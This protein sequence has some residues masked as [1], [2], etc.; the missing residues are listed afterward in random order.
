LEFLF[1]LNDGY[2][3]YSGLEAV[4]VILS[5]GRRKWVPAHVVRLDIPTASAQSELEDILSSHR[6]YGSDHNQGNEKL[7]AL[8]W[9]KN[10]GARQLVAEGDYAAG[11]YDVASED[12]SVV[13]ECGTTR[14]DKFLTTAMSNDWREFVLV[15]RF[16]KLAIVF[17]LTRRPFDRIRSI[18]EDAHDRARYLER[19][20]Q[21]SRITKD[22]LA[23]CVTET[24]DAFLEKYRK[25]AESLRG[26][27]SP[28]FSFS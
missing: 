15:P 24:N 14:M 3:Q 18:G 20:C 13:V 7:M 22:S 4:D 2:P 8:H 25:I 5:L 16:L 19:V 11:R 17:T 26:R 1:G 10:R 6:Y 9:L 23:R 27:F 12:L 28:T 21:E